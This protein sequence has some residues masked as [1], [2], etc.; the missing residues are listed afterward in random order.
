MGIGGT[1]DTPRRVNRACFLPLHPKCKP[2]DLCKQDNVV[3]ILGFEMD[4]SGV[5]AAT[6]VLKVLPSI[7]TWATVTRAL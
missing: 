4:C 5:D 6:L 1:E 3:R 7:Q 2:I